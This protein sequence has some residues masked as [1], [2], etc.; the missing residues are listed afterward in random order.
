MK[1]ILMSTVVLAVTASFCAAQT[2][3]ALKTS[4]MI[5]DLNQAVEIEVPVP[6]KSV[7]ITV[8]GSE[9][10]VNTNITCTEKG[11]PGRDGIKVFGW[12]NEQ[13][14]RLRISGEAIYNYVVDGETAMFNRKISPNEPQNSFARYV[15]GDSLWFYFSL[16]IPKHVLEED[17]RLF[18]AYFTFQHD[19]VGGPVSVELDCKSWVN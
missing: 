12:I 17:N 13:Q 4:A 10:P 1:R 5:M 14:A 18:R 19:E 11:N 9:K 8:P 6:A 2:P 15:S 7:A 3:K 16:S